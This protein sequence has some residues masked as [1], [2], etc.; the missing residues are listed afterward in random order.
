MAFGHFGDRIGRKSTLVIS[1]L[2]M[3]GSTLAIAFVPT[4][5]MVG[6]LAPALLC[7]L[8]FGQGL[9]LGGEWSG[10][11]LLAIE[12]SPKGWEARFGAAPALSDSR[13]ASKI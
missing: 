1:L 3:G 7:L 8:R 4:Y 13:T 2:L 6:W 9:G 5:A 12:N 10:A 11:A